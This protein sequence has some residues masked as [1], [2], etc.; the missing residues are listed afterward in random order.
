MPRQPVTQ[1]LPFAHGCLR[2][3]GRPGTPVAA[4]R[5]GRRAVSGGRPGRR[6]PIS[7]PAV[8]K[9]LK[10]LTDAGLVT[11]TD[12]GRERHYALAPPAWR[13]SGSARAARAGGHPGHGPSPRCSRDGGTA[14]CPRPP[15]VHPTTGDRMTTP[16]GRIER[17]GDRLTL[18]VTRTFDAP[19]ED[20]WAAV[21]EPER[22]ERWLGT[23]RGDPA[24]GTVASA[25]GSRVEK[26]RR[27][28]GDPRVRTAA[29]AQGDLERRPVRWYLDVELTETDGVTTLAFSQPDLDQVD[30][31]SVGPGWEYYLDRLVAV[32]TGGDPADTPTSSATTTRRW[33][34]TTERRDALRSE[35]LDP[36]LTTGLRPRRVVRRGVVRRPRQQVVRCRSTRGSTS[37]TVTRRPSSWVSEVTPASAMPQGTNRSYQP[38]STSQLRAKPCIVTPWLTRMPRAA[39]LRSG[40]RS[41]ARS[42]T[43]LRPGTRA[44]VTP[45]SAQTPI[46]ASSTRRT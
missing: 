30:S 44:L 26:P 45:R 27:A 39:T 36:R 5:G 34:S 40:P 15:Y 8:S 3:A 2:R 29:D 9:H 11:A 38:R 1:R 46:S 12:H 21:T 42:Q 41:S 16:T 7:R 6:R 43:P 19:I 23:W 32:E 10:V 4:R 28:D 17:V 18:F 31:L 20:V 13:R 33:R 37:E 14:D 35:E 22:L 25:M 24:C